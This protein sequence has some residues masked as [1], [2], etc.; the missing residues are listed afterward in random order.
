MK[1]KFIKEKKFIIQSKPPFCDYER[2]SKHCSRFFPFF[3]GCNIDPFFFWN[4][5]NVFRF[6]PLQLFEGSLFFQFYEGL[7]FVF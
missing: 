7:M 1:K 4:V 3:P 5:L 2:N 6:N